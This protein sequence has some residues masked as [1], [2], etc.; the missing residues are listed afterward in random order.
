LTPPWDSKFP[1]QTGDPAQ[2]H[3]VNG[4]LGLH[5]LHRLVVPRMIADM[6]PDLSRAERAKLTEDILSNSKTQAGLHQRL[7]DLYHKKH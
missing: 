4:D 5:D 7:D 2:D 1:K 3:A 6:T